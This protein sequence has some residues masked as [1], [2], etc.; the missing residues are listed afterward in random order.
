MLKV[1]SSVILHHL[2]TCI[3]SACPHPASLSVFPT[4][5]FQIGRPRNPVRGEKTRMTDDLNL[6]PRNRICWKSSN[7]AFMEWFILSFQVRISKVI[8]MMLPALICTDSRER[9]VPLFIFIMHIVKINVLYNGNPYAY[10]SYCR[11]L[12][13]QTAYCMYV[14]N[15][16]G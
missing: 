7:N 11:D 8:F 6:N 12:I 13:T 2:N 15:D 5:A 3:R 16:V 10:V 14:N 4:L 1:T 9:P